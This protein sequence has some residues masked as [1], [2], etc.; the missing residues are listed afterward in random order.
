MNKKILTIAITCFSCLLLITSFA[1]ADNPPRVGHPAW[2]EQEQI[3][4][5][6]ER[7][8]NLQERTEKA[9]ARHEKNRK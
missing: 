2:N 9:K 3:E 5:E 7:N 1:V 8:E 6:E 4:Q